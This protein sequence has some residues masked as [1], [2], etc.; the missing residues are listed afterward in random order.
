MKT[1]AQEYDKYTNDDHDV[2]RI[3]FERQ[4]ANLRDKVWSRFYACLELT[5]INSYG[6]PDFRQLNPR[7]TGL[8]GWDIRVVKGIIPVD[9][10]IRL[11]YRRHFCSS[12]WLR[13]RDQLDYL[14]EPDMFHDTFG[15]IPLLADK[16]YADFVYRFAELGMK[17][18]HDEKALV[19]LDRFYWFTIEFGL[20]KENGA[21]RIYGAGLISSFGEA[22]HVYTDAIEL[23]PFDVQ[24]IMQTPF[25]NDQVQNLYFVV[26]DMRDLWAS[27][28]EA[29][30]II[31]CILIGKKEKV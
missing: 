22:N 29:E 28:D 19:L 25:R 9:E 13:R 11:L 6:V 4:T 24:E 14:E 20:M 1:P 10:F 17:H 27:I 15:H 8:T 5:D 12:T 2:W 3:L 16:Q 21:L 30:K 18:I 26:Q 7:L 23:R 31:E